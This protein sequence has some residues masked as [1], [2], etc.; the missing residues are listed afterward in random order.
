MFCS[1]NRVHEQG[2]P[3][4]H[5]ERWPV[6]LGAIVRANGAVP[7]TIGIVDGVARVGLSN[8]ELASLASTAAEG[9]A[10]K[11]SRRDLGY[12]CGQVGCSLFR[13]RCLGMNAN[14]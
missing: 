1:A 6:H 3:F 4:P 14:N 10:L 7:A 9:N 11:V 12:V 5:Y 2:R 13:P 8:N